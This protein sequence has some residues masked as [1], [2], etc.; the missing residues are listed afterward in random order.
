MK[1]VQRAHYVAIMWGNASQSDPTDGI[2]PKDYGWKCDEEGIY[3][4]VWYD[5]PA[6][7]DKIFPDTDAEAVAEETDI[8]EY[9]YIYDQQS[10]DEECWNGD[11]ED[12]DF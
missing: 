8:E 10:S 6:I 5:G 9:V 4:P 3:S 2:D 7:P 1:K 11:S 12:N